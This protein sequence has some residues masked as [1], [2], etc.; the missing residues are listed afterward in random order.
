MPDCGT[1]LI[2]PLA[3]EV[4][5]FAAGSTRTV[6]VVAINVTTPGPK[7]SKELSMSLGR[8]LFRRPP[9]RT[10]F[11]LSVFALTRFINFVM[12]SLSARTQIALTH[13]YPG[14]SGYMVYSPSPASPAYLTAITNWDG[15]WYL[16]I[17]EQGYDLTAVISD[18]QFA[19]TFTLRPPLFP[20]MIRAVMWATGLGF[21]AA[22]TL[23][24]LL[25]GSVT[26]LLLYRLVEP[27][28]G[29]FVA[30]SAVALLCAFVSAPVLQLA[31]SDGLALMLIVLTML[32]IARRRYW[33]AVVAILALMMTRLVTPPLAVVLAAHAWTR[34]R[35]RQDSPI[36]RGELAAMVAVFVTSIA[37]LFAWSTI[38]RLWLGDI[39]AE[40]GR[41]SVI[42]MQRAGL[43]WFSQA[44]HRFGPPGVGLVVVFVV[45][46]V[47]L[48]YTPGASSW[49]AETRAWLWAYPAFLT[50]GTTVHAGQLR[51]FLADFPLMLLLVRSPP[52]HA[53]PK[54]RLAIVTFACLVGLVLQWLWIDHALI[55]HNENSTFW[56][57]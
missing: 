3:I 36:G 35:N 57:P 32:L 10:W 52:I 42:S 24:N 44:Y 30:G 33:F 5:P 47:A 39:D 53:S 23:V 51:Y 29:R 50:V 26:V 2:V 45:I 55:I 46:L 7:C 4:A 34:F 28:A 9:F 41:G 17:V 48:A 54:T 22:A 16:R 40:S 27:A 25:V 18:E 13:S 20:M 19:R 31:Y 8:S 6:R 11:P 15:Q 49:G 43:G 21:G 56:L 37:G 1:L 12:I 14:N 38:L